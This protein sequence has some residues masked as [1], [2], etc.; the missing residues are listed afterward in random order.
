MDY[1]TETGLV[2]TDRRHYRAADDS[3]PPPRDNLPNAND[4]P[5]GTVGPN[6]DGGFGDTHVMYPSWGIPP[7]QVQAWDGWPVEWATPTWG[8]FMGLDVMQSR[9]SIVAACIDLNASILSTMPAYVTKGTAPQQKPSWAYNP[10]PEVYSS[11]DEFFKQVVTS[12]MGG[13]AILWATSRFADDF[14]ARFV[15]LNPT[16]VNIEFVD[17]ARRY[18]L[19]GI[20]ITDDVLHIRYSSWPGDARGHGPLESALAN[21]VGIEAIDRYMTNLARRGG[22]PWAVLTHP[23]N[24]QRSQAEQLQLNFVNAKLSALGAPAVLSGGVTLKE[25]SMNPKDMALLELKS[26]S[27]SRIAVLCGVPPVLVGLAAHEGQSNTYGNITSFFDFHWRAYLRPKAHAICA[28]MSEWLLARG[29]D[30]ELNRDEYTRPG[31]K[32]RA[33]AYTLLHNI[34]DSDGSRA[35]YVPEIRALERLDPSPEGV[36]AGELSGASSA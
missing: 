14:P 22:I 20:D 35:L 27:E 36:A 12:Y 2:V 11:W 23:G 32:D 24:L 26:S 13:E 31:L 29:S 25:L 33:E 17:G 7:P 30:L 5:L 15:M 10:Q 18:E 19:G 8:S 28:A 9:S 4:P 6:T 1:V 21:L 3:R 16:W 34:V